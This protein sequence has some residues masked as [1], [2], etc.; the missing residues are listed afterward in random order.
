MKRTFTLA[1]MEHFLV[2]TYANL[3]QEIFDLWVEYNN[4]YFDGRLK[5]IAITI[6]AVAPHGRWIG[7]CRG[8]RQITLA[9]P[10][11]EKPRNVSG[12]GTLLHEMIHQHIFELG[13][14]PKDSHN[15]GYW[16]REVERINEMATGEKICCVRTKVTK[17]KQEDGSRKSVKVPDL[18][19]WDGQSR[20][21][22]LG[23]YA[24]WDHTK[25]WFD[26]Y[27]PAN[28]KAR[29][30]VDI[31]EAEKKAKIKIWKPTSEQIEKWEKIKASEAEEAAY[32][33]LSEEEKV[34][35]AKENLR[36]Q[37]A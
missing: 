10:D 13:F 8:T 16:R 18:R 1:D 4:T 14:F 30:E 12:P 37:A 6:T 29:L 20:I 11:S 25:I 24:C 3:G 22:E 21:V 15:N 19:D 34:A 7:L 27:Q 2:C 23:E 17:V 31:R 33:A 5:P 32:Q 28:E 26:N 36:K 35:L 9:M